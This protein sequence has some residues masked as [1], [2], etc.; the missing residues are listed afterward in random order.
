MLAWQ[1]VRAKQATDYF[2]WQFKAT[3]NPEKE[4]INQIMSSEILD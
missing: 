3:L 4:L 1:M 2:T